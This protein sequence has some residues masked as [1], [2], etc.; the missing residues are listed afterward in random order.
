M[1]ISVV[2]LKGGVGK[3][4]TAVALATAASRDGKD[5]ELYDCDPQS[6]ASLWAM[7]AEENDDPLPFPVSSANVAT[8]RMAGRK[9]K[10]DPD[11]WLFIDCPPNGAVTDEATDASDFVVVPT[12]TGPADLVKTFETARTL[13]NKGV[14]YAVLLTQVAM[15]TLSFTQAV[16]EM[17]EGD[18]SYFDNQ[19]RRR[20]RLKNFFGNSFG[21]DLFGYEVIWED[22]KQILSED[23]EIN[24]GN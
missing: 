21:D 17:R 10:N 19:I 24:Y 1:I 13:T 23:E 15:N 14:F 5:V 9:L 18:L 7:T 11:R 3:T 22:M 8:V 16:S 20:E 2:N 6:S 12:S 4:T